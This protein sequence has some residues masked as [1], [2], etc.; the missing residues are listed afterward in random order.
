MQSKVFRKIKNKVFLYFEK[1]INRIN[2]IDINV[3]VSK[4][5]K[6]MS[7]QLHGN[8]FVGERSVI[9]SSILSGNI[10]IGSNTTLWGP[11]IQILA[12][13]EIVSIGNFCSIARDVTIQEY[14]HDYTKL[15]T[16][17]IGRNVFKHDVKGEVVSKGPIVIGNDVWIGTGVQIMSGVTIGDGS[18]VAS[19]S[20]ITTNV[21]PYSIVAGVP[22]KVVKY[23]FSK[24]II[25]ELL[26][27]KWWNWD[28]KKII[29]NQTLF[30]KEISIDDLKKY[31][32]HENCILDTCS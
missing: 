30:S 26:R 25:D 11:N 13:K 7:S 21:E 17:F 32:K 24:E 20:T 28:M 10:S 18:V 1:C 15:T 9:Y 8:V 6:I 2:Y 27:I 16:Y 4:S 14:F 22:A 12:E 3:I 5:S 29:T 31:S 19:N 23:R